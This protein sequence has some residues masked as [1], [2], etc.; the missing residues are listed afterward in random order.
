[1]T[2]GDVSPL[3][4][5][6][7]AL[8]ERKSTAVGGEGTRI[9]TGDRMRLAMSGLDLDWPEFDDLAGDVAGS[10]LSALFGGV[11]V[12]LF[13]VLAGVWA[14]GVAAGMLAERERAR[15]EREAEPDETDV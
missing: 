13:N 4:Y 12:P 3:M 5:G 11:R 6:V 2:D 8:A 1:M 7:N 15:R 14:D 10:T 9:V